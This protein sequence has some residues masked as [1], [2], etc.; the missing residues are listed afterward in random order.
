[1]RANGAI[2]GEGDGEDEVLQVGAEQ[3]DDDQAEDEAGEGQQH[4]HHLHEEQVGAAADIAADEA[5]A[6][7][8]TMA[9]ATELSATSSE[10]RAPHMM[11]DS[12]S[13]PNESVPSR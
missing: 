13:R 11:R 4:V 3:R 8:T 9:A 12:T 7:P 1:M 2:G 5:D 6:P 10:M